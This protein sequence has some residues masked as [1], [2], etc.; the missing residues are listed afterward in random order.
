M[1]S[2]SQKQVIT[3]SFIIHKSAL[4]F[5]DVFTLLAFVYEGEIIFGINLVLFCFLCVEV[6]EQ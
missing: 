3:L 4:Q 5:A 6:G 2:K 1:L